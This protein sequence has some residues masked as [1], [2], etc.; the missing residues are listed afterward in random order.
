MMHANI[1]ICARCSYDETVPRISFDSNG[2]CNYCHLHDELERQYPTGEEGERR[3]RASV[4]EIKASAR[5]RKYDCVVG[6]SGGCDSSYLLVRMVELGLRP[7]AVHF[8]NTWNS[9]IATQN[10]HK[11][12]EKLDVD[13]YTV[14]VDNR[15]ID[16]IF[17]AF[18]LSGARDL[19]APTDLALA[20]VLYAAAERNGLKYIIEGHS[21]RT[22]GIAPLDWVYMDGRYIAAVHRQFGRRRMRTYPNMSL[23]QFVRWTALRGIRRIRPLYNMAYRKEEA[24]KRLAAEYGWEWYGGHHLENRFTA[25]CHLY[26]F[27]RRWRTDL[28]QLGHAALVRSGQLDRRQALNELSGP[29]DCPE[30]LTNLVKKRLG[31]DDDELERAMMQPHRTWRDFPNYKRSFERLRPLFGFLVK[32]GRIPQSFYMKFCFPGE[33]GR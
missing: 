2:V 28:R 33:L 22:E 21:F 11:L 6:V 25:F 26:A 31:F 4:A 12:V 9:P 3:L 24:K 29:V 16:D 23:Q 14:V 1:Q 13:L 30:E 18:L 5:S 15:E 32:R 20:S 17:R 7:L 27:P 19:D 8:D 10:I